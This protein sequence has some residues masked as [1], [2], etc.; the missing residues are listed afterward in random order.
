MVGALVEG[1]WAMGVGGA[2]AAMGSVTRE[3]EW[4]EVMGVV[5]TATAAVAATAANTALGHK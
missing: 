3:E 5:A 2:T 1:I 4:W